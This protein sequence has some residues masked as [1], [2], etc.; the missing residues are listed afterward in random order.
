MSGV[1]LKPLPP[2]FGPIPGVAADDPTISG[3]WR[4]KASRR[5]AGDWVG[6]VPWTEVHG[7]LREVAPRLPCR[8]R[9]SLLTLFTGRGAWKRGA[10]CPGALRRPSISMTSWFPPAIPG[11]DRPFPSRHPMVESHRGEVNGKN[12]VI[13]KPTQIYYN[14]LTA[15]TPRALKWS[16]STVATVKSS[17]SATAACRPSP[18]G[19]VFPPRRASASNSPAFLHTC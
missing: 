18:S 8:C 14:G 13:G 11:P 9:S 3:G 12:E 17:K 7:Y 16:T 2:I 6:R 1:I 15:R 19:T 10:N 4:I 5:D